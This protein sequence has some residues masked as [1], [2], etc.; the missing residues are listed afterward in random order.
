MVTGV[1]LVQSV[2]FVNLEIFVIALRAIVHSVKTNGSYQDVH[3]GIFR[4]KNH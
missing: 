1:H 4:K 3:V 2:D